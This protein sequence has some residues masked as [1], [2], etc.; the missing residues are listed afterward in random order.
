M[1]GINLHNVVR[2]AITAIHPDES[3]TLYQSLGQRNI[4]GVV[5][6]VYSAPKQILANFQPSTDPLQHT[7]GKNVTPVHERVYLYSDMELPVMGIKRLPMLRT[8]DI[9]LRSDG[10]YHYCS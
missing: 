8:G 1:M 4:K 2:G 9:I 5:K 10:T 7:D 6:S 3:C